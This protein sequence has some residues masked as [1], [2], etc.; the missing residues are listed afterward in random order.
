MHTPC[1]R[2]QAPEP[3]LPRPAACARVRGAH[4]GCHLRLE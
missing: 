2:P 4:P 3:P 1:T